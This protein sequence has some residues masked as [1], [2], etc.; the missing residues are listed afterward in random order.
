M[1]TFR[2][3]PVLALVALAAGLLTACN[4]QEPQLGAAGAQPTTLVV[5]TGYAGDAT[6]ALRTAVDELRASTDSGWVGRQDEVTGA[7]GE[8]TGGRYFGG[9][10]PADVVGSFLDTWGE[11]LFGVTSGDLALGDQTPPTTAGSTTIRAEQQVGGVPVLDGVLLF[12][13]GDAAGRP[14]LNAVRGRAFAGLEVPTR[15][16]LDADRAAARAEAVSGGSSV[17][18]PEL[19]VVPDGDGRLA[20]KVTITQ[21]DADAALAPTDGFYFIDARTGVLVSTRPASAEG[22]TP[23]RLVRAGATTPT[24]TPVARRAALAPLQGTVKVTGTDPTG[25]RLTAYGVRTRDGVVLFDS[26]VPTFDARTLGG[27]I[28][29]W[30][31]QGSDDDSRLPGVRYV[32][33]ST[34]I[35][36]P[37]AI[38]AQAFSR[39]V[40]D[41]YGSLGW[42]SWDDRGSS[43][44]SSIHYADN[45]F[46]NSYFNGFQ[47]VYGNQCAPDGKP[48][49]I[50]EL[51]IDTAAHEITHGVTQSSAGLVY[52]GQS[53]AMNESFSDYFGNVIGDQFLGSDS[54][55]VMEHVCEG[56]DDTI[57]CQANPDGTRSL[58][59]LP[60]GTTFDDY[61]FAL[62][63]STRKLSAVRLSQD[64]GGVHTNSAIWNNAL[65]SIRSRL[66][67]ID[68][69]PALRSQL[70]TDFDKI[71]FAT[72][73]TQ[74]GPT[75][76]FVDA[77]RAIEQTTVDAGADP[78]ILRV[79]REVFDQADICAG[80]ADTGEVVGEV[81]SNATETETQP[82]VHGER[83]A[84]LA[85][86]DG[87]FG[88]LATGG[89]GTRPTA[90]DGSTFSSQVVFAGDALVGLEFPQGQVP[91]AVVR[92]APGSGS[93]VVG[94]ADRGT[95]IA[96]LAGSD[97]GAAWATENGTVSYVDTRGR[98]TSTRLRLGN[99]LV[100]AVGTGD[101]VVAVGTGN[102]SLLVGRP[103]GRFRQLDTMADTVMSVAASGGR[104]VAADLQGNA[105]L[106]PSSGSPATLSTRAMPFG[107]AM[108]DH[109]AVWPE[110]VGLL[111]GGAA[112]AA[113]A[114]AQD[115]DLYLVSFDTGKIYD[116]VDTRGQQGFPAL[117][118]NRL[119]WQD[120]VYGGDDI[121]TAT[122]PSGL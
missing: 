9:S 37:E 99:D 71:V 96:G 76:G 109:Y 88:A 102:G 68:G 45:E 15:P 25:D 31:M 43:M 44:I 6:D 28:E 65:W 10:T 106:Y 108:N 107:V 119:V 35:S 20:W 49:E 5:A 67:Q 32:E 69:V 98:V 59:Y 95:A 34:R 62:D 48:A 47:M 23:V 72:L 78:V 97:E 66:A 13:I 75:A 41:Y 38:A 55:A 42:A 17:T 100:T 22:R 11:R 83:I 57:M 93:R 64:N 58:R 118:G 120:A 18:T 73:T 90:L 105:V 26:T 115:T 94:K 52:S 117:S 54:N 33:R 56:L 70:A 21:S 30:D 50:S 80:C 79:E 3:A 84:W 36:D 114:Q 39:A 86:G 112:K 89:V 1:P 60:N 116:L 110:V 40:Y 103:G 122:I 101:G 81:V 2:R 85:K 113:Q 19:V 82:A 53:G 74:L 16:V 27:G 14:R 121:L 92:F 77:R 8:L 51:D 61:F 46:C 7:L 87:G 104:V 63:S 91:G 24:R 4:G 12:T 111:G 29:T